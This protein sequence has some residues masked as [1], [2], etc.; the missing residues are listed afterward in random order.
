MDTVEDRVLDIVSYH[1]CVG[2]DGLSRDKVFGKDLKPDT[3]DR[4]ETIIS[5]EDEFG[6]LISETDSENVRSIGDLIDL[7]KKKTEM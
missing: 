1:F 3:L 2:K 5:I 6:I 4:I 7:V